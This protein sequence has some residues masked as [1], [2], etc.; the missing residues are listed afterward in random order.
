MTK[1][2]LS[3]II[4]F[5]PI[6]CLADFPVVICNSLE[7]ID[8]WVGD[9]FSETTFRKLKFTAYVE[10]DQKLTSALISGAFKSKKKDLKVSVT[11]DKYYQF[12]VLNDDENIFNISLPIDYNVFNHNFFSFITITT[13]E[14]LEPIYVEMKCFV[15]E[16]KIINTPSSQAMK[17]V[18]KEM[19]EYF[20]EAE[21]Y[22]AGHT[23]IQLSEVEM[24]NKLQR[25]YKS[26][27]D[28]TNKELSPEGGIFDSTVLTI[29][30]NDSAELI[31]GY[32]ITT[33]EFY[34][35]N[36]LHDGSGVTYYIDTNFNIVA[37][38]P[39]AG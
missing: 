37:E 22:R 38:E 8:G 5:T 35:N 13:E 10:D 36:S 16:N 6:I 11:T 1:L 9:T 26:I 23:S 24:P 39:W 7:K 30:N 19:G 2:F 29:I 3:L 20:D 27:I 34:H 21:I 17:E 25:M 33:D 4:T 31:L 32:I 28:R 12:E 18:A 14:D 15:K